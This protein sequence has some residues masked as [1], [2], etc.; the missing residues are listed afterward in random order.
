MA[1]LNVFDKIEWRFLDLYSILLWEFKFYKYHDEKYKGTFL[2]KN[3]KV[4]IDSLDD[5]PKVIY[6]FWTGDNELTEN[7]TMNLNVL[8]KYS[9][10][11][12]ILITPENLE[13]YVID[14]CPI[15]EGYKY[16]SLNHRSDYLRAYFMYHHGGGYTDIKNNNKNWSPAFEL[17]NKSRN[18]WF[19]GYQ[20]VGRYGVND[21]TKGMLGKDLKK[22]YKYLMG[23]GAF[24]FKPK[25]MAAKE[26]L[27]EI[28]DK[29]DKK[30]EVLK[31]NPSEGF[32]GQNE[33]YPF[34]WGE[35]GGNI[36]HPVG[37]KYFDRV[38][39]NNLV[40]PSM[41]NYR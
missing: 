25:S 2:D 20:E 24:I 8:K 17:L 7:R 41:K 10:V 1:S 22:Y 11:D 18:K 27:S 4:A 34:C 9:G 16:L 26:W 31:L 13:Q 14:D 12:V 6:T 38:I 35:F 30:L 40:L 19:L 15:H 32:F 37:L 21:V 3:K 39:F 5:A 29:L 23:N 36:Q 28:H 33:N